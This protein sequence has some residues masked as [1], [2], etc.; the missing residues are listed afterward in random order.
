MAHLS[1]AVPGWARAARLDY[2][3]SRDPAERAAEQEAMARQAEHL[4]QVGRDAG[5]EDRA[6][7]AALIFRFFAARQNRYSADRFDTV[8]APILLRCFERYAELRRHD[9]EFAQ[10]V[11]ETEA[12]RQILAME[13]PPH[14]G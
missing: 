7:H 4:A 6:D 10:R 12:V 11:A 2:Q 1:V 13:L 14:V 5:F 9:F 3:A 8:L